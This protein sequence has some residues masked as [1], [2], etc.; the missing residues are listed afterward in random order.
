MKTNKRKLIKFGNYS[1]CITLPKEIISLMKLKKGD[2]V[3]LLSDPSKNQIIINLQTAQSK[4]SK[5]EPES[6]MEKTRW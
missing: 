6:I 4:K 2:S 5:P 1:L 3:D